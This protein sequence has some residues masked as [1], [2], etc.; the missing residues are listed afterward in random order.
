MPA[1]SAEVAHEMGRDAA[2]ERLK[3]FSDNLREAYKDQV[4]DIEESWADD[5]NFN[6]SFK[7]F[8]M[9]IKGTITI[10]DDRVKVDG[11]LPFAAVAFRG[12]IEQEIRAQL[13][14]ALK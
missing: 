2:Q 6:F 12:K 10:D 3:G 1:F 5:G 11:S 9:T 7:T 13:E 4:K 8:G 14:K